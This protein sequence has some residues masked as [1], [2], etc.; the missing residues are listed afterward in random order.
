VP[1]GWQVVGGTVRRNALQYRSWLNATSP[2]R[3]T[4]LAINDPNEWSYVIPR[5]LLAA[6]GFREGS[7]YSGGGG[8]IYRVARYRDGQQFAVAWTKRNYSLNAKDNFRN[9]EALSQ[10]VSMNWFHPA[11]V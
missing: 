1:E 9:H 5:P 11:R 7:P 10:V 4:I 3:A 8:T 6:S 2:D